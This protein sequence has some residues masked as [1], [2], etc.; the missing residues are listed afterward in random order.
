M[1]FILSVS[2]VTSV[3]VLIKGFWTMCS[4]PFSIDNMFS[5]EALIKS[6]WND[7]LS[8]KVSFKSLLI[9]PLF[10]DGRTTGF[11]D[12]RATCIV[13]ALAPLVL[14]IDSELDLSESLWRGSSPSR[15]ARELRV[16]DRKV[17]R[18]GDEEVREDDEEDD[19][20]FPSVEMLGADEERLAFPLREA[21][22]CRICLG[23]EE[24]DDD[25][26]EDEDDEMVV[27]E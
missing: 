26:D 16:F 21:K 3:P 14:M 6:W 24:D 18:G 1:M 4:V 10:V 23:S 12:L 2:G 27:E 15:G 7:L 11:G 9:H 17:G 13:E 25:E 5:F 8:I 20:E 22:E 19:R